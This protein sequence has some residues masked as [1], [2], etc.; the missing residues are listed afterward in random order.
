V[1]LTW[2]DVE[3]LLGPECMVAF[4]RD[5]GGPQGW[6]AVLLLRHAGPSGEPGQVQISDGWMHLWADDADCL[7][8]MRLHGRRACRCLAWSGGAWRSRWDHE[9]RLR[10][11]AQFR[12]IETEER[13]AMRWE[14]LAFTSSI[15]TEGA[16]LTVEMCERAM[17]TLIGGV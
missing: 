5:I 9:R 16:A 15:P 13:D 12:R 4:D 11:R 10:I 1:I 2:P 17:R 8:R 3:R 14:S 7:E 6:D